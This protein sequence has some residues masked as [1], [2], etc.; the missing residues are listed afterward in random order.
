MEF[1][2]DN[3]GIQFE[4]GS[5]GS[6]DLDV[7][8]LMSMGGEPYAAIIHC[9]RQLQPGEQLFLHAIFEPLPLV[10][11]L[12]RQGYSLQCMHEGIDHWIVTIVRA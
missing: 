4:A 1:S 9:V 12:S 6:Y 5:D 8:E 7:R 3:D 2:P 11:K 10:K